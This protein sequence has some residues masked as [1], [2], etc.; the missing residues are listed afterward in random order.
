MSDL[1]QQEIDRIVC[2]RPEYG[3]TETELRHACED[4]LHT[5]PDDGMMQTLHLIR[6]RWYLEHREQPQFCARPGA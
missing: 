5:Y 2:C 3:I 6:Y 4:I 1:Q